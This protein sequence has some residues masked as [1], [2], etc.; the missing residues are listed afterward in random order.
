M[1]RFGIQLRSRRKAGI[2][3]FHAD[4]LN[5]RTALRQRKQMGILRSIFTAMS[6]LFGGCM[7]YVSLHY[8]PAY[9][10][11]REVL[12][13]A[14]GG[15]PLMKTSDFDQRSPF[16]KYV[17]PYV[18]MFTMERSF[19]Q[20]GQTV[21]LKYALPKGAKLDV[22]IRHCRRLWVV[23]IF[24][25][26]IMSEQVIRVDGFRGKQRFTLG[27]TGFYHFQERVTLPKSGGDFRV[28]WKRS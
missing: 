20:A 23:E 11:P 7:I 27:E 14:T 22:A 2:G 4:Y 12:K 17:G 19:I 3:G 1:A 9:V 21:D 28:V 18:D 5:D 10:Q 6:L 15:E 16:G 8:I 13:L 24:H 26:E 25:C